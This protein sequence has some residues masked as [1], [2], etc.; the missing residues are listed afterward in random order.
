MSAGNFGGEWAKHFF[1]ARNSR[2]VFVPCQKGA[3]STKTAKMTNFAFYPLITRASLLR[4]P[5]TT[6]MTKMAGVTQAKAWFR[7]SRACASLTLNRAALCFPSTL[8]LGTIGS[9]PGF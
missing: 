3:V 1:R 4:L 2:Q 7:K 8:K 9:K 5:K 6:K